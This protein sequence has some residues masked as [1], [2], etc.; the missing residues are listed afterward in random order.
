LR[1]ELLDRWVE[2]GEGERPCLI[3]PAET[4]T[5]AQLPNA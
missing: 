2:K 4:L 1:G 3:S 5:Y